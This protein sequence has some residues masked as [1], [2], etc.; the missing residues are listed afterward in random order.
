M[1]RFCVV[2]L[3]FMLL[4]VGLFS[5]AEDII[6]DE[7]GIA[8]PQADELELELEFAPEDDW[9]EEVI[10]SDLEGIDLSIEELQR[11]ESSPDVPSNISS[12]GYWDVAIDSTHFPDSNFRS[13][14]LEKVDTDG[15]GFLSTYESTMVTELSFGYFGDVE[16]VSDLKGIEY[17]TSLESLYCSACHLTELDVSNNTWLKELICDFNNISEL[18]V[19]NCKYLNYLNCSSNEL[20]TL[21]L[22]EYLVYLECMSNNLTELDVSMNANLTQLYVYDNKLVSLKTAGCKQLEELGC[23]DNVIRSLDLHSNTKLKWVECY[24]NQLSTLNIK[25][26]TKLERLYCFKNKLTSLDIS[27][28]SSLKECYCQYNGIRTITIGKTPVLSDLICSKNNLK[29]IDIGKCKILKGEVTPIIAERDENN[30]TISWGGYHYE[31]TGRERGNG[32]L[33]IDPGTTL[34][35]G[36]T[37]LY[38]PGSPKSIKFTRSSGTLKKGKFINLGKY[39]EMSPTGIASVCKLSSSNKKVVRV[40]NSGYAYGLKKGTATITVKTANGKKAKIKI[41]VK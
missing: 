28:C 35:S 27:S 38:K 30:N 37:I 6:G 23:A 4:G 31:D 9:F 17:F 16:S 29:S 24:N 11:I 41:K 40:D 7:D 20:E 12:N 8:T 34:K 15:D 5:Y 33:E 18:D 26:C 39:I 3:V 36:K 22:N 2:L 13:Y 19:S 1:K 21:K 32:Y 10:S 25:G 14:V